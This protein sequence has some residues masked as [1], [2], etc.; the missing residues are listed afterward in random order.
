MYRERIIHTQ[1]LPPALGDLT[2]IKVTLY[3]YDHEVAIRQY[4]G[5]PAIPL[6]N[7]ALVPVVE[8]VAE[9]DEWEA[10]DA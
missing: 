3:G 1:P 9:Y 10:T 2:A 7:A 5:T 4:L 6:G 8:I